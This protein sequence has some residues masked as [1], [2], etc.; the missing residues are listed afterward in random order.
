METLTNW[1]LP[2]TFLPG[3]ALLINATN[4]TFI[5]VKQEIQRLLK[6][7]P[8]GFQRNIPHQI[9]RLNMLTYTLVS[10]YI[11]TSLFAICSLIGGLFDVGIPRYDHIV[12]LTLCVGVIFLVLGTIL[13][14]IESILTIK[15]VKRQCYLVEQEDVSGS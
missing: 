13:L 8:D 9:S 3:V 14:V 4:Q 6:E 2:L 15:I 7:R 5:T 11:S 1:I 10:F 12:M